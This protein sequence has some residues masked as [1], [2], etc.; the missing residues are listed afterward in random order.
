MLSKLTDISILK[1]KFI[2]ERKEL[3]ASDVSAMQKRLYKRL[4][5]KLIAA[6]DTV[7]G[8]LVNNARNINA[9]NIVDRV[10]KE[11]EAELTG[12]MQGVGKDY[13]TLIKYNTDYFKQFNTALFASATKQ[14]TSAMNARVGMDADG[15]TKDGFIDS[16]IK[17]KTLARQV[18]KTVLGGVLTGTPI[19]ELQKALDVSLNGKTPGAGLLDNH[20][21][22]Y[23]YDTYSQFDAETGNQFA[24]QLD[25]NYAIF[26]GGLVDASRDFCILRND[27]A[28]T[29]EEIEAF[30]TPQDKFGGYTNKSKGE[31][32]G[33]N[34]DYLPERDRGGH[35]CGHLYNWCSYIVAKS[36][37]P[38]IPKSKYDKQKQKATV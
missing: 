2:N 38:D 34:K 6:L 32:A 11:F 4:F 36:K 19:K 29:R 1:E 17:D 8:N 33:K 16:F 25:L 13:G 22:T 14:V 21:R 20:F 26:A 31:F 30:G 37:R 28:F 12:T 35:N 27:K 10:F 9:A 23:I 3:L 5:D 15:F 18:K 24:V 7:D